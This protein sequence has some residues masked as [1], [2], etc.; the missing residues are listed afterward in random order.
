TNTNSC[1]TGPRAAAVA[2]MYSGLKAG[3]EPDEVL[4]AAER[5]QAL[6]VQYEEYKE[7]VRSSIESLRKESAKVE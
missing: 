4:A 3:A 5:D 1:R 6:F 7:W 2:Y